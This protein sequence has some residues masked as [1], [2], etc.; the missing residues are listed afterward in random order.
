P[1]T[2]T[3]S[4]KGEREQTEFVACPS[5]TPLRR[6]GDVACVMDDA[7]VWFGRGLAGG[8]QGLPSPWTLR[9]SL[10]VT[11]GEAGSGVPCSTRPVFSIRSRRPLTSR[12]RG[13]RA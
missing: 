3:L 13:A 6:A 1:L 12:E 5:D 10:L 11:V 9:M 4:R 2:P 7:Q 8:M